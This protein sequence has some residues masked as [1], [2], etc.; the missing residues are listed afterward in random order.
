MELEY[1]RVLEEHN[2]NEKELPADAITGIKDIKSAIRLAKV[3]E[4]KGENSEQYYKKAKT[5]DKWVTYEILDFINDSDENGDK[6]D[7]GT[8]KEEQEEQ[9]QESVVEKNKEPKELKKPIGDGNKINAELAELYKNGKTDL[10]INEIRSLAENCYETIFDCYEEGGEN[11]IETS[12]FSL[13]EYEEQK[14]KLTKK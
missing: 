10:S 14:Y 4:A 3:R 11:G 13:I 8:D 7:F 5:L 6:P 1:L 2:I 12:E 9:Q